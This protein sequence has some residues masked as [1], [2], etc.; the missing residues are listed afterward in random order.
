MAIGAGLKSRSQAI[1]ERGYDAEQVDAEI[2]ADRERA[3]GLGLDL[4]PDGGAATEGGRRWL[5]PSTLLTRRADAGA[6]H[7]R[8][9]ARTV[10]VIWS[11]GAPVRRRDMAGQYIE[12]LSLAP[13][14]VDLSRLEGA[15][16]LDAHR[17]TA[18]RDVLGSV[19]SAAV[20]GKRGTA[21]HPVLGPARGGADLAG[22]A[23]GHPAPCL[24]RL[25]G[26]GLGRDH[27]E[28]R[29]RADRRA[30][31]APRDFPGAD[32]RRPRRPHSHG[33]QR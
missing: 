6:R 27:R 29:A 17:Q 12:R 2:A 5:T 9:E 13:E 23:G 32:A 25:L 14:A 28:R 3:D 16:V 22:R 1:S 4:R 19:R 10:E 31:D 18:V 26:R 8:S 11:T 21:A 7:R 24:G 20:D 15:S 33:D 30:L